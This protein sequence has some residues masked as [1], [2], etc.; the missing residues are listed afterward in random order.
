MSNENI[1]P[2][3]GGNPMV[4]G[5]RGGSTTHQASTDLDEI[6]NEFETDTETDR[7]VNI[8]HL[9]EEITRHI[10]ENYVPKSKKITTWFLDYLNRHGP[11]YEKKV[12]GDEPQK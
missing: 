3:T 11:D 6:F 2:D 4:H 10:A 8:A 7:D 1:L 12:R 5:I 9:K